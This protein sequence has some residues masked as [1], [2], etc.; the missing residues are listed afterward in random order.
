MIKCFL[1][2]LI[3]LNCNIPENPLSPNGP[4][5]IYTLLSN[6]SNIK[7]W[8]Y[9]DR[10]ILY[11][12][13]NDTIFPN[14][15][16][17]PS[18]GLI[19]S[20]SISETL[21]EG[22]TFN[23]S[24]GVISGTPRAI[25][26][27]KEYRFSAKLNPLPDRPEN[28]SKLTINVGY[29]NL[30]SGINNPVA[31]QFPFPDN[32]TYTGYSISPNLPTGFTLNSQTGV[33][34]A[35]VK[36]STENLGVYKIKANRNDGASVVGTAQIRITEWV[37]EAYLKPPNTEA[38]D[39]F[40]ASVATSGETIVVGAIRESSNQ[41]T[42]TNGTL[43][44]SNNSSL[45]SGAAYVFKRTDNTWVNEAYLKAPNGDASDQFG[46]SVSIQ[47]DTIIVG[48]FLE[49]SNQITITNGTSASA[50]NS[51]GAAG[52]VYVFRRNGNAWTNEAYLKAP[53]AN[54]GD[55]F[56][57]S[58]SID[59]DTIVVGARNEDSNQTTITNGT[60]LNSNTLATTSGAAYVFRRTGNTWA[61][62]AYL[63][64]PNAETTD[65][66][67]E[68]VSISGDTIVVG[69]IQEDSLQTT[70]LNGTLTQSSDQ[71]SGINSGAAYVFRRTGTT[72]T[73]EAYLKA[74][75]A[76]SN[77]NFGTAV[78]I[79]GNTIVIG[80]KLE[81][82]NQ[83]TITN[84]SSASSDNTASDS[85]AAYVFRRTGST[86]IN[87]AY[88]KAP[89]AEG[90]GGSG[91]DHFGDSVSISVDTI[92]I[93]SPNED[94]IL[95]TIT[96]GTLVQVSDTATNLSVGAVYVFKR[97]ASLWVN[98]AYL[99][100]PN[101]EGGVMA[102]GDKFGDSV[103]I[104]GDTIVVGANQEDSNQATITNGLAPLGNN[105]ASN[106]GAVYVFRRK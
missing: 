47:G 94:S 96:N 3:I 42:V 40:G 102:G 15:P 48:S 99:K 92:V 31:I 55:H 52:A 97:A 11:Y 71:V 63:K 106:S 72:W 61:N 70:I 69:A 32:F 25:T 82:S 74:P 34:S 76:G 80:A 104:S 86:W 37:N 81:D 89:N 9:A 41:I 60:L 43:I 62:E 4:F 28:K 78:S 49:S 24:N 83:I 105:S 101:G 98:E 7:E 77:D 12:N 38:I 66:F 39:N 46:S 91:P 5:G 57:Y 1:L 35:S 16:E 13:L 30:T 8:K 26:N 90:A 56:G 65:L 84:G 36:T 22:L 6:L 95:T 59:G 29:Y 58:V 20:F 87:E 27:E 17:I 18:Q 50:D 67:G 64:A 85:G 103:F 2:F 93:G 79:S 54:A 21:P 51:S 14:T 19:N 10:E 88:L 53:N 33:I 100:S 73:N 75:N 23:S 68:S 44:S 45:D